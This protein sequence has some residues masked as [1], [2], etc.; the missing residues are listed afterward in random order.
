VPGYH[1]RWTA[2]EELTVSLLDGVVPR[3]MLAAKLGRTEIAI[4][5]RAGILRRAAEGRAADLR[6]QRAK[7]VEEAR[8]ANLMLSEDELKD[9]L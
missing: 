1:P 4:K 6:A 5:T 3:S 7:A 2:K 9:Y 8:L